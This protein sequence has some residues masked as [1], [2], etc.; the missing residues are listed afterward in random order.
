MRPDKGWMLRRKDQ[1]GSIT[2]EF[3]NGVDGLFK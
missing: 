1:F 2:E 3:R